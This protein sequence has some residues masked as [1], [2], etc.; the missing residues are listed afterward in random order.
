MS[1]TSLA[2]DALR[3]TREALLSGNDAVTKDALDALLN[4]AGSS[5]KSK[6]GERV[7]DSSAVPVSKTAALA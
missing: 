4:V 6:V 2:G 1:T 5:G 7:F 3:N